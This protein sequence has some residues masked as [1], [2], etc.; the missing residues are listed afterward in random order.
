MINNIAVAV[1]LKGGGLCPIVVAIATD[2]RSIVAFVTVGTSCDPAF[3]AVEAPNVVWSCA[4]FTRGTAAAAFTAGT[5]DGSKMEF[6]LPIVGT[7]CGAL[8]APRGTPGRLPNVAVSL[9]ALVSI[10]T[11][12]CFAS[13]WD[14]VNLNRT[15]LDGLYSGAQ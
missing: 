13:C 14:L 12:G 3:V 6:T 15:P 4:A 11:A 5:R 2:G 1:P 8:M 7:V 9:V 10:A